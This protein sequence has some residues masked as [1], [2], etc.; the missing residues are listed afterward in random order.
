M[1]QKSSF[2]ALLFIV[3]FGAC[4]NNSQ[5]HNHSGAAVITPTKPGNVDTVKKS[6]PAIAS[7]NVNGVEITVNYHSPAV[8]NRVIWGGL[9]PYDQVW[10]AG[11]HNATSLEVKSDFIFGGRKIPRGK[12]AFFIIP[13]KDEWQIILN[14]NWEQH[15]ADEYSQGQDVV[16]LAMKPN[17]T[18]HQERLMY[19]IDQTGERKCVLQ[20]RWEKL[21]VD[22]PMELV[23]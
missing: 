11:A 16:R 1:I 2:V 13:G 8:R 6:L 3:F 21:G 7:K 17:P 23:N 5:E 10:V 22:V 14:K 12:Y 19:A 20:M 9:V 4:K 15:L 18:Q